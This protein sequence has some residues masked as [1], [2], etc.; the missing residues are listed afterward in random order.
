M[1][2]QEALYD[3]GEP[4]VDL[5]AA[6]MRIR[7]IFEIVILLGAVSTLSAQTKFAAGLVVGGSYNMH[8]GSALQKSGSGV[9]FAGGGD[10]TIAF[11]NAFGI[12]TTVYAYDNRVGSYSH[13][14]SLAG[15]DYS[16]DVAVTIAYAEIEPKL[17][18]TMPD[19]RFYFVMGP[20]IGIKVDG[21]SEVTTTILTSGYS[22]SN[23][24]AYQTTANELTDVSTR[25]ELIFGG[26]YSYAIDGQ[27]RLVGQLTIGYGLTNI[28][29]NVDWRINSIRLVGVL[30]FDIFR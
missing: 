21:H 5:M 10:F 3:Q 17:K 1:L 6:R 14:L 15:I 16:A 7:R 30:E 4:G 18:Y 19:K 26:G 9:G 27:S 8:T 11:D 23:G 12:Q 25:L 20:N 29:K 28:E 24:L 13:D 2:Y 22:F